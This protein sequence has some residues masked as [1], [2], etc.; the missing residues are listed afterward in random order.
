MS[1][2]TPQPTGPPPGA[3]LHSDTAPFVSEPWRPPPVAG[4]PMP[5]RASVVSRF[6]AIL[7][8][9]IGLA[10]V[11]VIILLPFGLLGALAAPALGFAG[12]FFLVEIV[13]AL[14]GLLY[15]TYFEHRTGQTIGK[16]LIGIRVIDGRTGGPISLERSL[17]RNL[18]RIVD[19]LPFLYIVGFVIIELS[20]KHQRLGDIVADTVVVRV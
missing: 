15:F 4:V 9:T 16:R 12:S 5:V 1:P 14:L 2:A 7:I 10:L 13:A 19:M 20:Q 17:L 8:D 6:L 3:A 18:L 11:A